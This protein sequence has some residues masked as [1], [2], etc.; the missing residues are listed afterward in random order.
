MCSIGE[1]N[2][3]MGHLEDAVSSNDDFDA[4]ICSHQVSLDNMF[5]E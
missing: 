2:K 4:L 3:L 5:M 1:D